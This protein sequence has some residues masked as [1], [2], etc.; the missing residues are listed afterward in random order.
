MDATAE[1]WA[2]ESARYRAKNADGADGADGPCKSKESARTSG[3][4]RHSSPST[5]GE[6]RKRDG[7][8]PAPQRMPPPLPRGPPVNQIP[9]H[10]PWGR[11]IERIKAWR[12]NSGPIEGDGRNGERQERE[13]GGAPMRGASGRENRE[14]ETEE[15]HHSQSK[16]RQKEE[17][18]RRSTKNAIPS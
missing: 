17:Q 3:A 2:P 9:T 8:T 11:R 15:D 7:T 6:R 13:D 5:A 10:P 18:R 12:R 16:P 14:S 1:V 4:C